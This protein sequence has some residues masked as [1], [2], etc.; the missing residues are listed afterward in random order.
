MAPECLLEKMYSTNSDV[1]S[2][3][4]LVIEIWTQNLPFPELSSF[5]VGT[6]VGQMILKPQAPTDA[7]PKIVKLVSECCQFA[8][9]KRLTMEQVVESIEELENKYRTQ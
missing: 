9:K 7:H 3:G 1:W 2:F 6:K 4:I 8:A 5:E